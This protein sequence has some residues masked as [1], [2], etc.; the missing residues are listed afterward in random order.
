M[1]I[2]QQHGLRKLSCLYQV[3]HRTTHAAHDKHQARASKPRRG[4]PGLD[5]LHCEGLS[6]ALQAFSHIPPSL[7]RVH[8]PC[9][10][11]SDQPKCLHMSPN[12]PEEQS[13]FHVKATEVNRSDTAVLMSNTEA[14]SSSPGSQLFH[15][16]RA[17]RGPVDRTQNIWAWASSCCHE[18]HATGSRHTFFFLSVGAA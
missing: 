2:P 7:P 10:P 11:K 6:C 18:C 17:T 13:P 8:Q 12:S 16:M 4:H 14:P 9:L 5:T 3:P 15:H 1:S